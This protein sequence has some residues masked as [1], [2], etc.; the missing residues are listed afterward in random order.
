[1]LH[2]FN[3]SK[4]FLSTLVFT[5]SNASDSHSSIPQTCTLGVRCTPNQT[6]SYVTFSRSRES[7]K[8]VQKD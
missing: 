5:Y 3:F 7:R 6:D 1:M 2:G 8:I 4:L